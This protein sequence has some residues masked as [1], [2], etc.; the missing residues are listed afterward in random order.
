[1]ANIDPA[2]DQLAT[3]LSGIRARITAAAESSGRA[4][5]EVKLI[6]ISKTHPA[7]AIKRVIE[8]GAVDIGENRVQEAEEKISEIGRGA[9]RWHLVGH[10][11]ANKARRAVNLFDVI[12][13]LDSL[14]LARRLDRLCAEEGR[15]KLALLIQVDLGHEETKSGIDESE[16]THLVESLGP[17]TRLDLIGLM[18][19]PPFFDH[20]E[21]SRP[22]FRRL[23]GMRDELAARG[24]FGSGKG[25][26]SMGMT[27]DFEVAI[28]EGAT[29]V[30]IGTAI[31]GERAPRY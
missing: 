29:M 8:F 5:E 2:Q 13:S 18:T 10:L 7:S 6:A 25:E 15:E 11:Q 23:R 14:E 4:A 9:A 12:H 17:L 30:R 24:A 22:F 3:R 28:E 26:L 16:L 31:F 19:L 20:P 21:Q 27:H 1:M